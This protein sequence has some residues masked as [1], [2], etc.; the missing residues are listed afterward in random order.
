MKIIYF[1]F[2][3]MIII[4]ISCNRNSYLH[5][6]KELAAIAE[7]HYLDSINQI[8]IYYYNKS[9]N[10][11]KSE[12]QKASSKQ[13]MRLQLIIDQLSVNNF[14]ATRDLISYGKK[15][16]SNL[17]DYKSYTSKK[18]NHTY[19]TIEF[20]FRDLFGQKDR[21]VGAYILTI[22]TNQS[23]NVVEQIY[24]NRNFL[25]NSK[26][27]FIGE[28][29]LNSAITNSFYITDVLHN[30][31]IKSNTKLS[32]VR[33]DENGNNKDKKNSIDKP[34]I[35]YF[36][37]DS[38]NKICLD[39]YFET[40]YYTKKKI[41]NIIIDSSYYPPNNKMNNSFKKTKTIKKYIV[42]YPYIKIEKKYILTT[43]FDSIPD[44]EFIFRGSKKVFFKN[45]CGLGDP[46]DVEN[47][48]DE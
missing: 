24:P 5:K 15:F 12:Q 34:I 9:L 45:P 25:E 37:K 8:K 39:W 48:C 31:K 46:T 7:Q 20:E 29:T 35:K 26:S 23:K 19:Y 42:K 41:K 17:S 30:G 44:K 18:F 47:F 16:Y 3:L 6:K 28:I 4:I 32:N 38:N 21:L 33:S 10:Y 11:L 14:K 43:C 22:N 13:A 27:K 2:V 1:F 40:D 36:G